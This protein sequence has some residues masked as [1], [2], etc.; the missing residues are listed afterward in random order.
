MLLV[1]FVS[2]ALILIGAATPLVMGRVPPNDLYGLRVPA[3][4]QD[5]EV[6]YRAN[7]SSGRDFILLGLFE[8]VFAAG[9]AMFVPLESVAYTLINAAF[10]V[11]G[12]V[13]T[14]I[15]GWRRANRLLKERRGL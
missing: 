10:L 5:E 6:W 8:I 13:L 14:A 3:T 11:S 1:I 12:V 4:M 2:A 7:A 9:L 15:V